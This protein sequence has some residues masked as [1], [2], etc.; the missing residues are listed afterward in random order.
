ME[1]GQESSMPAQHAS[2]ILT[3]NQTPDE[4]T[5]KEMRISVSG[6]WYGPSGAAIGDILVRQEFDE[7]RFC[8][9]EIPLSEGVEALKQKG[10]HP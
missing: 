3:L 9:E 6:Y 10:V 8:V 4:L 1:D 2:L 7:M 5:S